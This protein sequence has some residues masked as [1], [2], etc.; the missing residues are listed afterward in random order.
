MM[1]VVESF[2]GDL[3]A[4]HEVHSGTAQFRHEQLQL[5]GPRE[6]NVKQRMCLDSWNIADFGLLDEAGRSRS[7]TS[8]PGADMAE[9]P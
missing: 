9:Q 6:R 2:R 3:R 7:T 8:D 1:K 4:K 5:Q